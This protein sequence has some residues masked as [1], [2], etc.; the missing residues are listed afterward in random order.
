MTPPFDCKSEP[1]G[2]QKNLLCRR[3]CDGTSGKSD[4][5]W[6]TNRH[7]SNAT[8]AVAGD[9]AFCAFLHA[10]ARGKQQLVHLLQPIG[11]RCDRNKD[12]C[13][14]G[15]RCTHTKPRSSLSAKMCHRGRLTARSMLPRERV[16]YTDCESIAI[17]QW[18][19]QDVFEEQKTICAQ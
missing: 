6:A 4:S 2:K 9:E 3:R 17:V 16:F 18:Q 5:L 14:L 12:Y 7:K 10:A 15:V 1:H 13:H 8:K 11:R 19:L